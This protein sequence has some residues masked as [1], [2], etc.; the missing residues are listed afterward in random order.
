M[1]AQSAPPF[2]ICGPKA[3][4]GPDWEAVKAAAMTELHGEK[5]NTVVDG[6][7][8]KDCIP[9]KCIKYSSDRLYTE[10]S[11]F[12][13]WAAFLTPVDMAHLQV[14]RSPGGQD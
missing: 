5:V 3:P 1:R 7:A 6:V 10:A 4:R 12:S 9:C 11:D 14:P 2:K 13:H 8:K